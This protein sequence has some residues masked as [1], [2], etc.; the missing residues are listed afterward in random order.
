M[1]ATP[2][3]DALRI[4]SIMEQA[5]KRISEQVLKETDAFIE[6]EIVQIVTQ[7]IKSGDIH[8][9][10]SQDR[11]TG[12]VIYCPYSKLNAANERILKCKE[13]LIDLKAEWGWKISERAGNAEEYQQLE[14]LIKE[15]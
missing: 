3:A 5:V 1:R 6:S 12:K 13:Y 9:Y 4:D 14:K 10:I 11:R 8:A 2:R 15:I 7:L